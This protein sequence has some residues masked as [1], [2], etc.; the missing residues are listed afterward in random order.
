MEKKLYRVMNGKSLCGV[1]TGFA[2]YFNLDVTIV[3][4]I[5]V[6]ITLTAGAGLLAYILCALL[7]P[8]EPADVIDAQ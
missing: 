2:R 8:E 4:V 6:L 5:W 3:R 1:C 7:I